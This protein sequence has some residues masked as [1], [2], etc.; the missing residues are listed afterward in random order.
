M[1]NDQSVGALKNFIKAVGLALLISVLFVVIFA[2][3]GTR[4]LGYL[5]FAGIGFLAWRMFRVWNKLT[6][7]LYALIQL[8]MTG[9]ALGQIGHLFWPHMELPIAGFAGMVVVIAG[10]PFERFLL[11]YTG[12]SK[13]NP[14]AVAMS[15]TGADVDGTP[16]QSNPGYTTR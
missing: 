14:K 4:P 12:F 7:Q 13:A 6:V 9:V 16:W 15:E 5:F 2:G 1:R 11:R 10:A 8:I 3:E